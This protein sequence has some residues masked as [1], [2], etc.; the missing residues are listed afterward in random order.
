MTSSKFSLLDMPLKMNK[1]D[2]GKEPVADIVAV[3]ITSII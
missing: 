3:T 2:M 1:I